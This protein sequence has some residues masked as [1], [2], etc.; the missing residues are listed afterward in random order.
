MLWI[1]ILTVSNNKIYTVQPSEVPKCKTV[2]TNK[3]GMNGNSA[4]TQIQPCYE[5][6]R[7]QRFILHNHVLTGCHGN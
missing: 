5:T 2:I 1:Q 4:L 7:N 3:Q 6:Q